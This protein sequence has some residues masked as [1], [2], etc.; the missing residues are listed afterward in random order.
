M[1]QSEWNKRLF[2]LANV[3]GSHCK[4]NKLT[5]WALLVVPFLTDLMPFLG[6][7]CHVTYLKPLFLVFCFGFFAAFLLVYE[8]FKVMYFWIWSAQLA[9]QSTW[10]RLAERGFKS[11]KPG[12][13]KCIPPECSVCCCGTRVCNYRSVVPLE[14]V[15]FQIN[16]N[17]LSLI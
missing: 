17:T 12:W 5:Y 13:G 7:V 9:S 8:Y 4:K 16:L 11:F 3:T 1:Y 14:T 6:I 15:N 2:L 10:T